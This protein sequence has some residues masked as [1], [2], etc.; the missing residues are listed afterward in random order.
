MPGSNAA[1]IF[2]VATFAG[3]LDPASRLSRSAYMNSRR[4]KLKRF[5]SRF[6]T[7]CFEAM[8]SM[9]RACGRFYDTEIQLFV[10]ILYHALTKELGSDANE[11]RTT[12]ISL[13]KHAF[14]A[15]L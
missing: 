10:E 6:Q 1:H 2:A 3:A 11:F 12:V 14:R 7:P 5:W 8:V 9:D 4:V 15:A 13:P